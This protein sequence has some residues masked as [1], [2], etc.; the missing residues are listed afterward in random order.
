M[1]EVDDP[2]LDSWIG[3]LGLTVADKQTLTTGKCLTA[4][5]ISASSKL[6]RIQSP[7]QN[8]LQDTHHLLFEMEWKSIPKDFVQVIYVD[9]GHWA[10]LSNI[11]CDSGSVDLYDSAITI[12]SKESSIVRQACTILKSLDLS[13]I[14]I[15]VIKVQQQVGG[16]DCGLFAIAMATELCNNTDPFTV[17]YHQEQL[18]IHLQKCFESQVLTS[19]PSTVRKETS[20]MQRVVLTLPV[21]V[22]CMCRQPETIPMARCDKCEIWYHPDCIDVPIPD[23][24]FEDSTISWFCPSCKY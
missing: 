1:V 7:E 4:N 16:T 17:W 24:I 9:P 20:R 6:L 19:F 12:P 10:C 15:N 14:N 23:E 22:Y 11:S 13:L 5:H 3:Q 2:Y 21:E 8:G 18:R